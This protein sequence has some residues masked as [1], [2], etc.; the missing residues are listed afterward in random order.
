M[1]NRLQAVAG[2]HSIYLDLPLAMAMG[3]EI[4]IYDKQ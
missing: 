4:V 1:K 2:L 3:H